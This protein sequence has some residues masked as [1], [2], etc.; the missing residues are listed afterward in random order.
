MPVILAYLTVII[1]WSTTPLAIVLSSETVNPVMAAMLRTAIAAPIALFLVKLLR[2]KLPLNSAAI[3]VYCY[4]SLNIYLGMV[5]TYLAA[6]DLPSGVIS[7]VY[8]L[9]PLVSGLLAQRVIGEAPFG[10]ARQLAL[11]IAFSG[12]MVVCYDNLSMQSAQLSSLITLIIGMGFFAL[13]A[14]LVKSVNVAIHP[15]ATTAGALWVSLPFYVLTWAL[16]D[17]T[18]PDEQ[19]QFHSI[20]A[21]LYLGTFGSVLGF[22]AYYYV[23]QKLTAATVGLI[24]LITPVMALIL[25]AKLNNETITLSILIGAGAI[26]VGLAI[27]QFGPKKVKVSDTK[28]LKPLIKGDKNL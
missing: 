12:L 25:G 8:G 27:Y 6:R 28:L 13:S 15:L 2:V 9:A 24:T 16:L 1:I 17:G 4:S 21:I 11:V 26:L 19:W 18:I 10:R 22:F 20:A 7:L 23:L 5:L 14:V 3:K